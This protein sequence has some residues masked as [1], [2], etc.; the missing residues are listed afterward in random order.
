VY[1]IEVELLG[2][3]G[4]PLDRQTIGGVEVRAGDWTF[5]SRRVF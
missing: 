3:D 1:D 4:R 5:V 2:H